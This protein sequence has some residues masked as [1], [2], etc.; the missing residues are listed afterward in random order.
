MDANFHSTIVGHNE[1]R[2][3]LLHHDTRPSEGADA[4]PTPTGEH[5]SYLVIVIDE[6][7][8]IEIKQVDS[9]EKGVK[10]A[11]EQLEL[12]L[13][14]YDN[15]DEDEDEISDDIMEDE[16]NEWMYATIEEPNAWCNYRG[17]WDAFVS[18]LEQ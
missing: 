11:N 17:S 12:I 10:Y 1:E 3:D 6:R 13:K 9:L 8:L 18:K 7:E 16:F 5:S 14:A 15:N 4:D 2:K